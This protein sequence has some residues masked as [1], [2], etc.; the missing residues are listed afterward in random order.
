MQA[1]RIMVAKLHSAQVAQQHLHST[2]LAT[3]RQNICRNITLTQPTSGA[4]ALPSVSAA[5]A[6]STSS[7][8]TDPP[9]PG[10]E[11]MAPPETAGVLE[12]DVTQDSTQRASAALRTRGQRARGESMVARAEMTVIT[13]Q[14]APLQGSEEADAKASAARARASERME[15]AAAAVVHA[16]HALGHPSVD[17]TAAMALLQEEKCALVCCVLCCGRCVPPPTSSRAVVH[18]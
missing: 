2:A 14:D 9:A 17:R 7:Q 18:R 15:S 3:A 11:V 1:H 8:P 13:W 12:F 4:R 10:G 16:A 6:P 5:L